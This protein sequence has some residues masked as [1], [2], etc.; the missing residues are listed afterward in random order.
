MNLIN[1]MLV[2]AAGGIESLT[3]VPA[4]T[5]EDAVEQMRKARKMASNVRELTPK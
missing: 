5:S 4:R 3:T 2:R 1:A